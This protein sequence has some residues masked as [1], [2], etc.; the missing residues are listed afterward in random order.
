MLEDY[1]AGL[2]VDRRADD[3]DRAAGRTISCPTMVL[4]STRDDLEDLYGDLLAI[5]RR[6]TSVLTGGAI[7][8]GHHMAEEASE[9]LSNLLI[10]FFSNPTA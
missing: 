7:E 4:W 3:E 9:E 10:R 2:G 5:W 1:R 8:S 6:W